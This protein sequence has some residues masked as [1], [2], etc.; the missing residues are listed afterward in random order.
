MEDTSARAAKFTLLAVSVLSFIYYAYSL[1]TISGYYGADDYFGPLSVSRQATVSLFTFISASFLTLALAAGSGSRSLALLLIV[2]LILAKYML[3]SAAD[4][5]YATNF[6]D[7]PSHLR[8]GM[9]V[10]V[11]GRSDPGVDGYFDLQPGFFWTTAIV[12]NVLFD[13]SVFENPL[14][15]PVTTFLLKWFPA[16]I[17]LIYVVIFHLLFREYGLRSGLPLRATFIALAL[18]CGRLHYSA[19]AY[20]IALY[21]LLLALIP[22]WAFTRSLSRVVALSVVMAAIVFV[23]QGI[24]LVT[25]V[26]LAA[27]YAFTQVVA[28][29]KETA[30]PLGSARV[31]LS[32]GL[33]SALWFSYLLYVSRYTF[34]DFVQTLNDIVTKYLLEGLVSVVETRV[35]RA[36]KPWADIVLYKTIYFG[37]ISALSAVLLALKAVKSADPRPKI[38]SFITLSI[39]S[40]I[41]AIA[42]PLGAGYIERISIWLL[43]FTSYAFATHM[44]SQGC[45]RRKVFALTAAV[46]MMLAGTAIY[47]SGWNFQSLCYSSIAYRLFVLN[48]DPDNVASVY[49]SIRVIP[50]QQMLRLLTRGETFRGF[51]FVER[52]YLLEALYYLVGDKE[53][54]EGY[55]NELVLRGSIIFGS[56][57]SMLLELH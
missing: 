13:S 38:A 39:L 35:I 1:S 11:A 4:T 26:T 43:P 37:S 56:P 28:R 48:H 47:F 24:A 2:S 30:M 25:L 18:D 52:H 20:G 19:H 3:P 29:L 9:F 50:I 54:L 57:T 7:A 23:H 10:T 14:E 51:V 49:S 8:R 15:N 21:W 53:V 41:G 5:N 6:Y 36:Y 32:L 12:L 27:L 55:L 17:L 34:S 45:A 44:D 31:A 40:V 42:V 22:R 16:P 46:V 33:F